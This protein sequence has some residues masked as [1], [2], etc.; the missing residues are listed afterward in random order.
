MISRIP[1]ADIG[2]GDVH[3]HDDGRLV[4]DL[5]V[6]GV[7]ERQRRRD[8]AELPPSPGQPA[9]RVTDDGDVLPAPIRWVTGTP[10]VACP[11]GSPVPRLRA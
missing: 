1:G 2:V 10:W 11:G 4:I 8:R 7:S 6:L 3:A 9:G 5:P